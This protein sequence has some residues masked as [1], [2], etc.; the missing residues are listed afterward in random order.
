MDINTMMR[1]HRHAKALFMNI[2]PEFC[3]KKKWIPDPTAGS[4]KSGFY[5]AQTLAQAY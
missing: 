3:D 5:T 4:E 1:E 2:E